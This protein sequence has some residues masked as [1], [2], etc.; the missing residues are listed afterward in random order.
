MANK[1]QFVDGRAFT[2][3]LR[4]KRVKDVYFNKTR[5]LDKL[6]D[7]AESLYNSWCSAYEKRQKP[8][9]FVRLWVFVNYALRLKEVTEYN[10]AKWKKRKQRMNGK[11]TKSI[12]FLEKLQLE[13]EEKYNNDKANYEQQLK[14]QEK[15]SEEKAKLEEEQKLAEEMRR[16]EASKPKPAEMNLNVFENVKPLEPSAP[17]PNADT[18][19]SPVND[20]RNLR[21]PKLEKANQKFNQHYKDT[22]YIVHDPNAPTKVWSAP[23]TKPVLPPKVE[24]KPVKKARPKPILKN[25]NQPSAP[26]SKPLQPQPIPNQQLYNRMP[27][28]LPPAMPTSY[29]GPIPVQQ[30][31]NYPVNPNGMAQNPVGP[32]PMF[33]QPNQI[34][35]YPY[36]PANTSFNQPPQQVV[37]K[38][39][40]P[41][42]EKKTASAE[43]KKPEQKEVIVNPKGNVT[44]SGFLK[45]VGTSA[46]QFDYPGGSNAC[47]CCSL[48]FLA[49]AF[50]MSKLTELRTH[51]AELQALLKAM[52]QEG[53]NKHVMIA[54]KKGLN[55]D[56]NRALDEVSYA[57]ESDFQKVE[58]VFGAVGKPQDESDGAGF[59][60]VVP[61]FGAKYGPNTGF[62][63]ICDGG[64][65]AWFTNSKGQVIYFDSHRRD[66]MSGLLSPD[67]GACLVWFK[68]H[69]AL[70]NYLHALFGG[71]PS[72]PYEICI[73][74]KL[75]V[76]TV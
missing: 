19:N 71:N 76:H 15:E 60:K 4:S 18:D 8:L 44:D 50:R 56:Q 68:N 16:L 61:W 39:I 33:S 59:T 34:P 64:A 51:P 22:K 28:N 32:L 67:G 55:Q 53:V 10:T 42:P 35:Q 6:Y 23:E 47:L 26:P 65:Y 14:Q 2:K 74:A 45:I 54:R 12:D 72:K 27:S 40:K 31:Y 66:P 1:F 70:T 13:L 69:Y 36:R 58:G 3:E 20:W 49:T 17:P 29:R 30:P 24:A 48:T 73:S 57:F 63:L 21:A 75:Q 46:S 25:S 38:P 43:S 9:A 5:K 11:V 7:K 62:H 37:R 52:I 41:I